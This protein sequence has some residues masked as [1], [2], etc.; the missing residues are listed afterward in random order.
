MMLIFDILPFIV[1]DS[2][3]IPILRPKNYLLSGQ[4][5]IVQAF[6]TL[7][8]GDEESAKNPSFVREGNNYTIIEKGNSEEDWKELTRRN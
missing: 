1:A 2:S 4:P 5:G 7:H 3:S 6:P 8:E